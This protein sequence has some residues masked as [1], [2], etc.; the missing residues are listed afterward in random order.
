MPLCKFSQ[1][2]DICWWQKRPEEGFLCL[3]CCLNLQILLKY[4]NFV[5]LIMKVYHLS[6]L[7]SCETRRG[8]VS[9][10]SMSFC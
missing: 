9:S 7:H 8:Q 5:N 4:L 10:L 2:S 6:Y 3:I 1:W